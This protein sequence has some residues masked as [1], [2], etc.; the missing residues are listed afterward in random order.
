M[1]SKISV[2][3]AT[4]AAFGAAAYIVLSPFVPTA[5][6]ADMAKLNA[7]QFMDFCGKGKE[8][9]NCWHKVA[10]QGNEVAQTLLCMGYAKGIAS[11]PR[12]DP[13]F[14][15]AAIWCNKTAQHGHPVGEFWLGILY[16][17]GKGVKKDNAQA[18]FWLRKAAQQKDYEISDDAT[19]ELE[20]MTRPKMSQGDIQRCETYANLQSRVWGVQ[21]QFIGKDL[22]VQRLIED[23]K[24]NRGQACLE[25]IS[26]EWVK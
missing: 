21:A 5:Q 4:A 23:I 17:D 26:K 22:A 3:T 20:K 6:A 13:N 12:L 2:A 1:L 19:V 8:A 24:A 18:I 16:R 11:N 25:R 10:E 7:Q 9:I 14:D 15:Q